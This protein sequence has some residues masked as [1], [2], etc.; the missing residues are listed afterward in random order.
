MGFT[1]FLMPGNTPALFKLSWKPKIKN[2]NQAL[3]EIVKELKKI[4]EQGVSQ[5]ELSE[6]KA[7]LTGSFPLR[8]DTN[9]KMVR[10]LSAMELYGL[11][12]DFPEKYTKL[13]NQ[14]T[15][16]EVLRVARTY[17]KPDNFLLVVVGD[18]KEIQLKEKW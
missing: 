12:L 18:Q 15:A 1:A 16:E 9:G 7:Y 14:V 10:L 5:T 13:I 2:T 3:F 17:L 11:G 8:M 4:I 6:A